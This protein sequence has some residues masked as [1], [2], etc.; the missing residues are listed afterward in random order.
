MQYKERTV[1]H[2]L[3]LSASFISEYL[4]SAVFCIQHKGEPWF[5][6]YE[7]FLKSEWLG[8]MSSGIES[9]K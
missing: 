8:Y 9:M 6:C 1:Q 5:N 7:V 4:P 2:K 3:K